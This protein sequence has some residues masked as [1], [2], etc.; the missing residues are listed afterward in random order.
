MGYGTDKGY[1]FLKQYIKSLEDQVLA[2]NY[3]VGKELVKFKPLANDILEGLYELRDSLMCGRAWQNIAEH[4][5]SALLDKLPE[6]KYTYERSV[7][8]GS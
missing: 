6:Q 8:N 4:K 2:D 1:V 3:A 7:E 5:L